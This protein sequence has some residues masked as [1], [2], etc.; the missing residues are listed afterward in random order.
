MRF[1][2]YKQQT[3]LE[4]Y[5]KNVLNVYKNSKLT[6]NNDIQKKVLCTWIVEI[7]MNKI[8]EFKATSTP[9]MKQNDTDDEIVKM[10]YE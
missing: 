6:T 8:N 10:Q 2:K 7:Q 1:L 9:Q 3:G 4:E 5:L